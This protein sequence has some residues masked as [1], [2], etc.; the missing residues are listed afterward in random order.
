MTAPARRPRCCG[1]RMSSGRNRV[2]ARSGSGSTYQESIR[3]T[4]RPAAENPPAHRRFPD[5]ASGRRRGHRRGRTGRSGGPHRPAGLGVPRR[6][7]AAAGGRPPNGPW[8][9]KPA[10]CRCPTASPWNWAPAWA[11]GLTA[12]DLVFA[13][14]PVKGATVLVAGGAGAVG[15]FSIQFATWGGAGRVASTVST[16]DK[17]ELAREAGPRRGRLHRPRRGQPDH[18][19]R[20]AGGPHRGGGARG[21]SARWTWPSPGRAPWWPATRP[22][23]ATRCCRSGP[24]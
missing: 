15:H 7:P 13:D 18:R 8:S 11:A 6:G 21:E 22:S 16:P 4:S 5:P 24:A 1:W 19:R 3:P 10:R 17:A 14:G 2:R 12:H 9:R 23:P 20:G